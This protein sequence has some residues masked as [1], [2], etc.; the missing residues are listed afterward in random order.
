MIGSTK[1]YTKTRTDRKNY[2]TPKGR[3]A[4]LPEHAHM[5]RHALG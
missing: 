1:F 3:Y 2:I 4:S 5:S